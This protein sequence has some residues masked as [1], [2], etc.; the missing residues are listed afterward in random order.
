MSKN[1]FI[2]LF[3]FLTTLSR[4]Y[5]QQSP[6]NE[7]QRIR[8]LVTRHPY[9]VSLRNSDRHVCSG[10]LVG[11]YTV[12]TAAH[13]VDPRFNTDILPSLWLNSTHSDVPSDATVFRE[14]VEVVRHPNYSI[15]DASRYDIAILTMNQTVLSLRPMRIYPL[16]TEPPTAGRRLSFLG[17]IRLT[18]GGAISTGLHIG[19]LE[20]LDPE[21]CANVQI[22]FAEII[23]LCIS[24]SLA[25]TGEEGGPLFIDGGNPYVDTLVA[26]S[27]GTACNDDLV[28]SGVTNIVAPEIR[29]WL[30]TTLT[31]IEIRR[32][33]EEE[34]EEV[35]ED[36]FGD[37]Q[38]MI[39][40]SEIA[41]EESLDLLL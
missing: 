2:S 9:A 19:R 13:C 30:E 27:S 18:T 4:F 8:R 32:A 7:E 23:M 37:L 15:R 34:D 41:I 31:E 1:R 35:L 21:S 16:N 26:I 24:E 28:V 11:Q 25:C 40:G 29:N 10:V 38:D 39:L 14:S 3:L 20:I 22:N 36:D 33:E 12:L 17:Y 6:L 5:C